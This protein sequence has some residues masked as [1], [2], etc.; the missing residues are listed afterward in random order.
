MHFIKYI[1]IRASEEILNFFD[2][3]VFYYYYYLDFTAHQDYFTHS[4]LSQSYGRAKTECPQEH[5]RSLA[6]SIFN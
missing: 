3:S 6:I 1:K 4:A 2:W 5:H